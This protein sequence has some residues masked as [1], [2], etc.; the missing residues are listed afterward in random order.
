MRR[1]IFV[2][3]SD[4]HGHPPC[5]LGLVE[6]RITQDLPDGS[7]IAQADNGK[8]YRVLANGVAVE[9]I[10]TPRRKGVQP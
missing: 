3:D 10:E 4:T 2:P 9:R 7:Q 8:T 1:T 5:R 6:A